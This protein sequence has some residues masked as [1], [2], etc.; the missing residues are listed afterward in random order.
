MFD[1][2]R[3]DPIGFWLRRAAARASVMRFAPDT[4]L[5]T[6]SIVVG[7]VSQEWLLREVQRDRPR[8]AAVFDEHPVAHAFST[9]G[10]QH[11]ALI[12]E[13]A[14]YLRDLRER[15]GLNDVLLSLRDTRSFDSALLQLAYAWRLLR[16]GAQVS[17]EPSVHG[18][19]RGD[20]AAVWQAH[21][22]IFECFV[23]GP[24]QEFRHETE[25]FKDF[26]AYSVKKFADAAQ[27]SGKKVRVLIRFTQNMIDA[28]RHRGRARHDTRH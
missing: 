19:R 20:I 14:Q 17:F 3:D 5:E 18:G 27:R 25:R 7:A 21:P 12:V 6:A 8:K 1:E 9:D 23:P 26:L 24:S 16:R 4:L 28:D 22:I 2:R 10:D 13:L 11:L 15:P